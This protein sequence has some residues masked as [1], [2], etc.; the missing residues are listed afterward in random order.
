M[1]PLCDVVVE[2]AARHRTGSTDCPLTHVTVRMTESCETRR[3]PSDEHL[4]WVS[5]RRHEF[6]ADSRTR[7]VTEYLLLDNGPMHWPAAARSTPC[8]CTIWWR[9]LWR[10]AHQTVRYSHEHFACCSRNSSS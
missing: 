1:R 9:R 3:V 2:V 5:H 8:P 6:D 7:S 10:V 4:Y